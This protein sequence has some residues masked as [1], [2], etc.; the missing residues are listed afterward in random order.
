MDHHILEGRVAA[1][2]PRSGIFQAVENRTLSRVSSSPTIRLLLGVA[3]LVASGLV[4]RAPAQDALEPAALPETHDAV[5]VKYCYECHDALSEKGG[6]N[7]EDLSFSLDSIAAAE[8]WQKVLNSLNSG[9]MPPEDEPQLSQ[10]E[11]IALLRD[12][13]DQLVVAREQLRDTGGIS[14]MRRLNR[15]EYENTIESLLGV[16]LAAETLPDDANSGGFDTNGSALFFSADQFE[17][18]LD[19]ARRALD[20]AFL[21]G[22]EAPKPIRLEIEPEIAQNKFIEKVSGTIKGNWD[23]AQAWRNS[24]GSKPPSAFGLLDEFDVRFRERLYNQQYATY[25]RYLDDPRTKNAVLL[26][27]FFDRTNFVSVKIPPQAPRGEFRIEVHASPLEG[28]KRGD[29][30]LEYGFPGARGGEI[31]RL[32]YARVTGGVGEA[33]P[34]PVTL[35]IPVTKDGPREVVIRHRQPN[36][37]DAARGTF[38]AFQNKHGFGPPAKL[39]IDRVVLTGPHYEQWP[40]RAVK[41]VFF[42][43]MWW[44]Q[45]DQDA[46]ARQ[47]IERF[48][49]RAFRTREPAPEFLDRLHAL[50]R[51]E[52]KAGKKFYEAI[53]E[54]LALVLASPGFLYL[55]EPVKEENRGK[56]ERLTDPE[57]AVRLSYLL[58]SAPPDGELL[59]D[60]RSGKLRKPDVL[61]AHAERLLDDRRSD[62]FLASLAHQW[63]HME[64]LDFFQFDFRQFPE[65]DDSVK[66]AARAEVFETLRHLVAERRPPSDLLDPGYVVV[67]DLL[68]DYYGLP[69]V[70]GSDYRAVPVPDGSP[71]GGLLGM[72]AIHAMGSDGV[73]S[74]LVERGAWVMRYLLNDPPP[75]APPNVPQLSRVRGQLLSPRQE[76]AAHMEEAQCAQC[77]QRIDP[78]GYGME[79][80]D[81]A[82][83]WRDTLLLQKT[84]GKKVVKKK[85]IDIDPSG[86]LPDGTAFGNFEELR[87]QVATR[88][89]AFTRGFLE[90]LIEYGLGRPY[91]F[92]DEALRE[93]VLEQ[94]REKDGS[95]RELVLGFIESEPFGRKK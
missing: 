71:R 19:L 16:R 57:L 6:L 25:R 24:D 94:A 5:L 8:T 28:A 75:P 27:P 82:G 64:R 53:R 15:R 30:Y 50:Y 21:F 54:P 33:K 32:G 4:C 93:N 48:A 73:H 39:A 47:V 2:A 87:D 10:D 60:A 7:L 22:K 86:T 85:T 63:L 42:K 26:Q 66:E 58:W 62:A 68:A 55:A 90:A 92:S 67:N 1:K 45:P 52:T 74:S 29:T 34:V 18:Y 37:R 76:L 31:E 14:T 72:A 80:F 95:L 11:K 59:A 9:E 41:Q 46:Y 78:I 36:N 23:K 88:D 20:E 35:S 65:F 38:L 13:S 3:L 17:Q 69:P 91:G 61:R 83:Q 12:L 49:K 43:G 79:N 89:E 51:T 81:A 40:P 70:E 77:H 56:S 84:Q 44:T